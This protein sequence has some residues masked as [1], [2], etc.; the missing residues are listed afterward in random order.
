MR[1]LLSRL[2]KTTGIALAIAAVIFGVAVAW[3]FSDLD[4]KVTNAVPSPSGAVI[5]SVLES[6]SEAGAAPYGQH[7]VLTPRWKVFF[8]TLS[9]PSFAGYCVNGS[10]TITWLSET[11]LTVSCESRTD[12]VVLQRSHWR[13][14]DI[15]YAINVKRAT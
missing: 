7:L 12:R 1:R 13:H 10:V 2:A 3:L 6:K 15:E 9:E 5:A 8:R 4:W 14:V 11:K